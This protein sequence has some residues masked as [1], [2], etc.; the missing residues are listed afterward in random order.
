MQGA[1]S[2]NA[3]QPQAAAAAAAASPFDANL[4]GKFF[5][6][7]HGVNKVADIV[8][9]GNRKGGWERMHHVVVGANLGTVS[10]QAKTF[11]FSSENKELTC[12]LSPNSPLSCHLIKPPPTDKNLD[13]S[14]ACVFNVSVN[15]MRSNT[16]ITLATRLNFY[17]KGMA[18]TQEIDKLDAMYEVAGGVVAGEFMS[19]TATPS[20]G[21]DIEVHPLRTLPYSCTNEGFTASMALITKNNL[22]HG[23]IQISTEACRK[24]GLP[25]YQGVPT[26]SAEYINHMIKEQNLDPVTAPAQL[27]QRFHEQWSAQALKNLNQFRKPQ[28]QYASFDQVPKAT[29]F[30][31][32]PCNHVLAWGFHTPQYAESKGYKFHTFTY[33]HPENN[34]RV[35][36][37][38]LINNLA[39]DFLIKDFEETW[40]S[41]VDV[42]PMD[43]C[44]IQMI[45]KQTDQP[46]AAHAVLRTYWSFMVPENMTQE[47][48]DQLAPVLRPQFTSPAEFL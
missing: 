39:F 16:P 41:L 12:T 11:T 13:F 42:R 7:I 20:D 29:Y 46:F 18:K 23:I 38:Y 26:L 15:H 24:I 35:R 43:T 28:E 40:M 36:L 8:P 32:I 9:F 31:A 6:Y 1:S 47:E 3:P 34:Q 25:V 37:Y 33:T 4:L 10:E 17:H 48:V 5:C 27:Q 19:V 30:V 2:E 22:R 45:A 21:V 14:R 44:G